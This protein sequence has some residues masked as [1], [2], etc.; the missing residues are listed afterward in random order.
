MHCNFAVK[1]AL[2]PILGDM[3]TV[4]IVEDDETIRMTT[5]LLLNE[6]GYLTSDAANGA[7]ALELFE[8]EQILP[9]LILCDVMMPVMD[10]IEFLRRVKSRTEVAVIPFIFLTAKSD[11]ASIRTGMNLGADD[12]LTKP[13]TFSELSKAVTA[14]LAKYERSKESSRKKLDE[15]RQNI[16]HVLPHELLT[17]INGIIGASDML[18]AMRNT[19]APAEIDETLN[20]IRTSGR[21][22]FRLVRN[23][24]LYAQIELASNDDDKIAV[25]RQ[26]AAE[27]TE[28]SIA[29][30]CRAKAKQYEREADISW[31]CGDTCSIAMAPEYFANI[32]E[33]LLDN[34]FKFSEA[35]TEVQVKSKS[36]NGL[37][38]LQISDH[39]RG[40]LPEEI[41]GIGAFTQFQRKIYEQQGTGLGLII[42]RQLITLHDGM[43]AIESKPDNGV[44]IILTLP[45]VHFE[46]LEELL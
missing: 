45:L 35:G 8:R 1:D 23:I 33:E 42:A 5:R 15:L 36:E 9:D 12:Y 11:Q 46:E 14:G 37:F 30:I 26:C 16:S 2:Q 17:P 41:K 44:T 24:L 38:I 22:L 31:T 10:G 6:A 25:L 20:M 40:M 7:E 34:A 43:F 27:I 13:F 39:G 19:L 28:P 18:F 21:R 32:V 3:K 4:L 29:D